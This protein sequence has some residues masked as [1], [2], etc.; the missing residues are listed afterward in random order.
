[1]GIVIVAILFNL[2]L[3]AVLGFVY[4]LYKQDQRDTNSLIEAMEL[5]NRVGDVRLFE[6][7]YQLK[8]AVK[9]NV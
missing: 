8:Q 1:M 3:V 7:A 4:W 2:M 6:A 9:P 5:S